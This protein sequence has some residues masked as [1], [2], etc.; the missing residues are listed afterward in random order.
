MPSPADAGCKEAAKSITSVATGEVD[1][2][3][4]QEATLDENGHPCAPGVGKGGVPYGIIRGDPEA[5]CCCVEKGLGC[6]EA[7]TGEVGLLEADNVGMLLLRPE[8]NKI[9]DFALVVGET[10]DIVGKDAKARGEGPA[11]KTGEA[12]DH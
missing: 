6:V 3:L 9:S 7:I 4:L 12:R 11:R 5:D 8:V 1:G 2:P 10:A